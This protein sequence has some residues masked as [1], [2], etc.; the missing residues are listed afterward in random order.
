MFMLFWRKLFHYLKLVSEMKI[1]LHV[2]LFHENNN[3]QGFS[4]IFKP[5][6]SQNKKTLT[7]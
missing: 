6:D 4:V 3:I 2:I 1:V 7:K 5:K